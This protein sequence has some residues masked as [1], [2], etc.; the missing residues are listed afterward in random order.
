MSAPQPVQI[1]TLPPPHVHAWSGWRIEPDGRGEPRFRT[2]HACGARERED[3]APRRADVLVPPAYLSWCRDHFPVTPHRG[4]LCEPCS[5]QIPKGQAAGAV[6][7]AGAQSAARQP[8]GRPAAARSTPRAPLREQAQDP[9]TGRPMSCQAGLGNADSSSG[10]RA[11]FVR[12]PG[13]AGRRADL[14]PPLR[15]GCEEGGRS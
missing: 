6:P 10:P 7:N 12:A 8:S 13:P 9:S 14:C 15:R 11:T 5:L 1:I 3:D 2:C 4:G